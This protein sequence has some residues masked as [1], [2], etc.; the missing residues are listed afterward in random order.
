MNP[1]CPQSPIDCS[2]HNITCRQRAIKIKRSH[3]FRTD[4]VNQTRRVIKNIKVFIFEHIHIVRIKRCFFWEK[5][6]RRFALLSSERAL[7]VFL[8]LTIENRQGW[9]LLAEGARVDSCRMSSTIFRGTSFPWKSRI[10]LLFFKSSVNVIITIFPPNETQALMRLKFHK[11]SAVK[12]V[13]RIIYPK[14]DIDFLIN[15]PLP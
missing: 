14:I 3:T 10:A 11:R 7:M 9:P 13:S 2:K 4:N 1:A 8:Q 5:S 12:F 15:H 6:S